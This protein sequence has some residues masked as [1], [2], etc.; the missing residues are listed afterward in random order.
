MTRLIL[1][2]LRVANPFTLA[3][4]TRPQFDGDIG[5][6][7]SA[8]TKPTY[9]D[10]LD[11]TVAAN[12]TQL[13]EVTGQNVNVYSYT[14]TLLKSTR[15]NEFINNAG[16]KPTESLIRELSSIPSSALAGGS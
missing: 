1:L 13:V 2:I 4:T 10:H 9:R 5:T 16:L 12:G 6:G 3:Q 15:T 11:A 7:G 14:G 8:T